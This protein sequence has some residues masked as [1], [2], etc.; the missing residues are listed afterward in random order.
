MKRFLHHK[1]LVIGIVILCI[2]LFL[3]VKNA[4]FPYTPQDTSNW[5]E[6][7]KKDFVADSEIKLLK[8]LL[9]F[10]GSE[11]E[12]RGSIHQYQDGNNDL[13]IVIRDDYTGDDSV[14][15]IEQRFVARRESGKVRVIEYGRRISCWRSFSSTFLSLFLADP[16][17]QTGPCI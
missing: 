1:P 7:F 6:D 2:I 10:A 15:P 16:L 17:W 14:G 11:G 13:I 3:N 8:N 12:F 5:N 4:S 9:S